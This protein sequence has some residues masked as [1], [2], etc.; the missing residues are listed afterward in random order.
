MDS[1]RVSFPYQYRGDLHSLLSTS[2][3]PT[4]IPAR[5]SPSAHELGG[6][7]KV[8][9]AQLT[10]KGHRSMVPGQVIMLRAIHLWVADSVKVDRLSHRLSYRLNSLDK[11]V[12]RA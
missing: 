7:D 12:N 4:K 6:G 1:G 9:L 3:H 5:S 10:G 8:P 2:V 11:S